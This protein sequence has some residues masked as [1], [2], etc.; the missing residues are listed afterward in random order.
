MLW[1]EYNARNMTTGR[2]DGEFVSAVIGGVRWSTENAIA[3]AHHDSAKKTLYRTA[4]GRFFMLVGTYIAPVDAATARDLFAYPYAKQ[5][6]S[7]EEA[8]G[9]RIERA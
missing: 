4:L 8:F 2:K 3:L 6:V 7:E 1:Y 9:T 5:L